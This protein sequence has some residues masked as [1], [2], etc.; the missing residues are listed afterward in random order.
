MKFLIFVVA[1]SVLCSGVTPIIEFSDARI[2]QA[3]I[4][5]KGLAEV[6][7]DG[8]VYANVL[9][10]TAT[11]AR[12][13][14][15]FDLIRL[16]RQ[17]QAEIPM[18]LQVWKQMGAELNLLEMT[19]NEAWSLMALAGMTKKPLLALQTRAQELSDL[20]NQGSLCPNLARKFETHFEPHLTRTTVLLFEQN[21]LQDE[22]K[23][24]ARAAIRAVRLLRQ[25][26]LT[27]VQHQAPVKQ[28]LVEEEEV[29]E[30][31]DENSAELGKLDTDD[32]NLQQPNLRDG[33][34]SPVLAAFRTVQ[35]LQQEDLTEVEDQAS[36]TQDLVEEEEVL[37][38][39]DENSAELGKLDTDDQHLGQPNLRDGHV[40]P[41]LTD[42][43]EV[44]LEPEELTE[45]ELFAALMAEYEIVGLE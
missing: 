31:V 37:E 25:E 20:S 3:S 28:D 6:G 4:I 27:K 24:S 32:Q 2:L 1:G 41:V 33:H 16:V 10:K 11:P 17:R 14:A 42:L 43:V 23:E 18:H 45:E 8:Q 40:S 7:R 13:S 44:R 19:D 26:N 5:R 39:V 29:L 22:L 21:T 34:V 35:Q 36:G 15:C 38:D 12:G 30:D 9:A